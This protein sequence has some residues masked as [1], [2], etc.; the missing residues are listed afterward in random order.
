MFAKFN[1]FKLIHFIIAQKQT[2][3]LKNSVQFGQRYFCTKIAQSISILPSN[4]HLGKERSLKILI[5]VFSVLKKP[6]HH[7]W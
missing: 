6:Y 7:D 2:Y 4:K 3:F 5:K 1:S